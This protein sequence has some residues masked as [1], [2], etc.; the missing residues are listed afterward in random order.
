MEVSFEWNGDGQFEKLQELSLAETQR[1][2]K[3]TE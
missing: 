1:E 2:K 3:V